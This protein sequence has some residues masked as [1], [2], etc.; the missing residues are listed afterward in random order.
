MK[1]TPPLIMSLILL[2]VASACGGT[3]APAA[4]TA[5]PPTVIPTFQFQSPTPRPA[6]PTAAVSP[7]PVAE[8]ANADAEAIQRG[9]DRFVSLGCSGCHGANAE[10]GDAKALAGTTMS[11]ND[12]LSFLRSGGGLGGSHQFASNRIS[13]GGVHNIYLYLVSL[14][15]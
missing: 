14:G 4:T 13:N 11:E 10:G 6:R 12:F 15:S 2:L 7:T 8:N 1:R 5:P 3:G 9:A